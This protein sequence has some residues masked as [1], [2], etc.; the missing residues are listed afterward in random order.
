MTTLGTL[1]KVDLRQAWETEAQHFT[2]WLATEDNLARL[3]DVI[4]IEL[5]LEAQEQSVGPFRADILCKDT[6]NGDWVLIENQLEKTDHNHL[7]QLMTY[8][9]GLKAVTIVWIAARFTEEHRAAID[10][11]NDITDTDFNFFGIEIELW[12]IGTS[13]VAP[14]FNVV[15]KPNDWSKTINQKK[16][17]IEGGDLSDSR[18]LALEY[19]QTFV[20]R[21]ATND[22]SLRTM[23]P[24]AEYSIGSPIGRS[25]FYL[26]LY[27]N[28][29]KQNLGLFLSYEGAD[30]KRSFFL[31]HQMKDEIEADFGHALDWQLAP[32][33][34]LSRTEIR[35]DN[36]N[37]ANQD[38]WPRQH[39]WLIDML[40]RFN[41][42]FR[43]RVKLIDA[44]EAPPTEE[45]IEM[46][47]EKAD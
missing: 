25:N 20:E 41:I 24:R 2:P 31:T 3:G 38:D 17:Q 32:N 14:K 43:Q 26:V 22:P 29:D 12:R 19:W 10:W 45:I 46:Y 27:A 47:A 39:D 37:P 4:G 44:A 35:M 11:F 9:A 13:P 23:K 40:Q 1:Q 5:E 15:S 18:Q 28:P 16:Q 8:A 21:L 34:K 36:A 6:A 30:A 42:A 33:K 7:G